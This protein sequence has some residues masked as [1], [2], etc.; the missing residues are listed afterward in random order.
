MDHRIVYFW[1]PIKKIFVMN[2][3]PE[4]AYYE[5][6]KAQERIDARNAIRDKN[7]EVI[8]INW[9]KGFRSKD[10]ITHPKW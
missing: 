9:H 7:D 8:K 10:L 1:K 3:D 4:N 2:L 5:V 6:S